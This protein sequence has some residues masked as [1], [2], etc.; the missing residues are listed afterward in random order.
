MTVEQLISSC[1]EPYKS[2]L[3]QP[4]ID[5]IYK[6]LNTKIL[7]HKNKPRQGNTRCEAVAIAYYILN[8]WDK[9]VLICVNKL[10]FGSEII[11]LIL[12]VV[13]LSNIG[14]KVQS[15]NGDTIR[16][17]NGCYLRI[18]TYNEPSV[19]FGATYNWYIFSD[20]GNIDEESSKNIFNNLYP[21]VN[22]MKDAK[23]SILYYEDNGFIKLLNR[24][25]TIEK[26]LNSG[27]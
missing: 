9:N 1:G 4:Q 8:N 16:F 23:L 2:I 13:K 25:M 10:S 7:T 21:V 17:N 27:G 5:H 3:R 15:E 18:G 6:L 14:V 11:H 20:F 26:V 19:A 24:K 22:A 12:D